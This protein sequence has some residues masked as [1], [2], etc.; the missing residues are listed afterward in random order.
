MS[1]AVLLDNTILSNFALVNRTDLVFS[2]WGANCSTTSAVMAEYNAGVAQRE[3][4]PDSWEQLALLELTPVEIAFAENLS[5]ILGA[6]ERSCLAIAVNRQGLLVSDDADARRTAKL[7]Q[8][9][10]SGTMGVLVSAV[11]RGHLSLPVADNLLS[12]MITLGYH[13]PVRALDDLL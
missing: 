11:R 4:P 2:L 10:V 7:Y 13:S 12:Q 8:V 1:G 5:T 3:L 6:G 9:P